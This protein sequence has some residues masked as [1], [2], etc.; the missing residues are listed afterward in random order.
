MEQGPTKRDQEDLDSAIDD[1]GVI[2]YFKSYHKSA[3]YNPGQF[4]QNHLDR[5]PKESTRLFCKPKML[6]TKLHD[7][8]TTVLYTLEPCGKNTINSMVPR[9]SAALGVGHFTNHDLRSTSIVAMRRSNVLKLHDI[10]KITGHRG[11]KTIE[12]CYNP[13][14]SSSKRAD[15]ALAILQSSRFSRG[16]EF[17]PVSSHM[18]IKDP[19]NSQFYTPAEELFL[20][21]V[22]EKPEADFDLGTEY[23]NFPPPDSQKLNPKR[24]SNDVN[25]E[26]N[27]KTRNPLKTS[28]EQSLMSMEIGKIA[29][30]G[31]D[32]NQMDLVH[33]PISVVDK[34]PE[35]GSSSVLFARCTDNVDEDTIVVSHTDGNI[36]VPT[37]R[38]LKAKAKGKTILNATFLLDWKKTGVMPNLKEERYQVQF[39]SVKTLFKD[40][41][42]CTYLFKESSFKE[43]DVITLIIDCGG[44]FVDS[45][46]SLPVDLE[47]NIII[48]SDSQL[49][50]KNEILCPSFITACVAADKLVEKEPFL[51]SRKSPPT[52]SPLVKSKLCVKLPAPPPPP[53]ASKATL[54]TSLLST[55]SVTNDSAPQELEPTSPFQT[56][57]TN[58]PSRHTSGPGMV[59][60]DMTYPGMT[61]PAMTYPAMTCPAMSYSGLPYLGMSHPGM[62][63]S[64]IPLPHPGMTYPHPAM[65]Y[66]GVAHPGNIHP[67]GPTYP[68]PYNIPSLPWTPVPGYPA[69][70]DQFAPISQ[71]GPTYTPVHPQNNVLNHTA[72][73]L[74]Y[75][76]PLASPEVSQPSSSGQKVGIVLK[77]DK[78][79]RSGW[80]L[81]Q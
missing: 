79:S 6:G 37:L 22:K 55:K 1:R 35:L 26:P 53:P 24:K 50:V 57:V 23:D 64:G 32:K 69:G 9:I 63:H 15:A 33:F 21:V 66:P 27:K 30:T 67:G 44:N 36:P 38:T 78:A 75:Q 17:Q 31:F 62:M 54:S 14:M 46:D 74:H 8:A 52:P 76:P 81:K 18:K 3:P 7:P 80:S 61:Y 25:V 2:P 43:T 5:L 68:G 49:D 13:G 56:P 19:G 48:L 58:V 42:F 41:S 16:E 71:V 45:L 11:D 10:R 28:V 39:Q 51:Y 70:S 34:D 40:M 47:E 73:H 29:L 65:T 59:N 60:T 72:Y 4:F 12:E 20:P 77:K